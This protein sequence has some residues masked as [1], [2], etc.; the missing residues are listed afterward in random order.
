[1][2]TPKDRALPVPAPH[3]GRA[4]T[5]N[6]PCGP[7]VACE[8]LPACLPE[9]ARRLGAARRFVERQTTGRRRLA[10]AMACAGVA[11]LLL[12]PLPM[13]AADAPPTA[14]PRPAL[15]VTVVQPERLPMTLRLGAS[16]SI[17]AWQ[18]ASV[19]SEAN[20]LRLAEVRAQVGD[21]VR[22]GQ[23]LATFASDTVQAELAQV[24]ATMAEAEASLAEAAANAQRARDLQATGALSAQQIQ[25]MLTAERM[26]QARVEATRAASRVQELRLRQAQVLAPDDG[27]ISVRGATVGAVVPAGQ[28]LFRLIRQGR[29]EW[30]AEVPSADLAQI[31]PGMQVSVQPPGGA[32]VSGRVRTV[33]PT[34]DPATR[35]GI[36]QVDLPAPGAAK[37]GMFARG[38]FEIASRQALTLPQ[39]A[40]VLRDG[41][42]YV[43]L[44]TEG[45]KVRQ[46]KIEVGRRQGERIEILGPLPA[47]ARVVS[48]GGGF[49][50]DGDLVRVV[51]AAP[52]AQASVPASAV[53]ASGAARR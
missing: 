18:E 7:F 49:L 15:S 48:A 16:G 46:Q 31:R 38:E 51:T 53:P 27:V 20:G 1:M 13:R 44:L 36:V 6:S 21:W 29:L 41:F 3:G 22:R 12:V 2:S 52:A 32:A 39:S 9:G 43:F 37:A 8:G 14:A 47:G 34:V 19:G 11:A 30:R 24:R 10:L 23:V 26:A 17:A 28:E 5:M 4:R 45:N 40:V 33:A 35:N 25:Q 42:H 50:G